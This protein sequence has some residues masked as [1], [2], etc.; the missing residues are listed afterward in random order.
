MKTKR[1]LRYYCDH[2]KK[3]GQ[4]KDC[5]ARHEIRCIR[6]PLRICGFCIHD[7]RQSGNLEQLIAAL[8][9]EGLDALREKANNCPGCIL[10]AI[11]QSKILH[12]GDDEDGPVWIDFDY[13]KAVEEFWDER[14]PPPTIELW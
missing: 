9:D 3:G 1:V 12:K 11:A 13:K 10:A 5:I 7:G 2:C 14:Q 4:R 8:I 6:N